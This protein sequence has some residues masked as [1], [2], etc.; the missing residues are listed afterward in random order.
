MDYLKVYNQRMARQGGNFNNSLMQNTQLFRNQTFYNA[1]NIATIKHRG[2]TKQ[3]RINE[4]QSAEGLSRNKD[5]YVKIIFPCFSDI[6]EVGD[7][8]EMA[9]KMYIIF[10]TKRINRASATMEW[11]NT[12][13]KWQDSS[14]V[15]HSYWGVAVADTFY[16]TGVTHTK[17]NSIGSGKI[18]VWIQYNEETKTIDRNTRFVIDN[19]VYRTTDVNTLAYTYD[20]KGIITLVM[21]EELQTG[22]DDINDDLAHNIVDTEIKI[23]GLPQKL[24]VGN[25]YKLEAKIIT[26]NTTDTKDITWKASHGTI[27]LI[28][29][30][31]YLEVEQV[32]EVIITAQLTSNEVIQDTV[33]LMVREAENKI[34]YELS[35]VDN[36][37]VRKTM[38]KSFTIR[39]YINGVENNDTTYKVTWEN[40]EGVANNQFKVTTDKNIIKIKNINISL[41]KSLVLM[42]K[43]E[44]NNT[45]FV[46]QIQFKG[47]F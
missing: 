5:D 7:Y 41:N 43:D 20:E 16:N 1:P 14:G 31:Y 40:I 13:F 37:V 17:Y 15:L 32:G 33:T 42:I 30:F 19:K 4:A 10:S 44:K 28:D 34:R 8:V 25:K 11:C 29:G 6:F 45:S 27:T 12:K 38:E 9:D 3:V 2:A 46:R 35:T 24:I 39:R 18:T 22:E 26:K 47:L 23:Q 36:Y 21:E